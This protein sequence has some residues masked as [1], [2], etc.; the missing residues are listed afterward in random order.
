MNQNILTMKILS[1][2]TNIS[3]SLTLTAALLSIIG[4]I[5]TGFYPGILVLSV[6]A[7]IAL[8]SRRYAKKTKNSQHGLQH[9]Y[10][11]TLIIVNLLLILVV[12]WMSFVIVHDRV[13]LAD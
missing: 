11:T 10:T 1:L 4:I 2:I 7:L 5:K 9:K 3:F 8:A 13:L 6:L 12:V